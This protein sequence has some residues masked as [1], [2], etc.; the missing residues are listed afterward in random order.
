[1]LVRADEV[2]SE[3]RGD[4][5]AAPR[6]PTL[7]VGKTIPLS[8]LARQMKMASAELAATLVARGFF[9]L[10]AKTVLERDTARVIGESFGFRVED[11]PPEAEESVPAKSGVRTRIVSK[12]KLRTKAPK[13]RATKKVRATKKAKPTKRRLAR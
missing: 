10:T 7:I 12:P 6:V 2:P 3:P 1:D 8:E 11:A 5:A 13:A 9:A 4:A